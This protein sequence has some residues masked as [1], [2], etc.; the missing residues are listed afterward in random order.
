[1]S[2]QQAAVSPRNAA[3]AVAMLFLGA[4]VMGSS[5]LLI[6]GVLDLGAP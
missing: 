5:E 1:V 6:V 4:F 2:T 3:R